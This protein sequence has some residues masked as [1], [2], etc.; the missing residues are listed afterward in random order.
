MQ[1]KFEGIDNFRDYG[2][3]PS[4]FGGRVREGR[5]YRSAHHG[6]ATDEDLNQLSA[7][8]LALL[9]DLRRP[10]ERQREPSRRH[11]GFSAQVLEDDHPDPAADGY[12][13]FLAQSDHSVASMRA[14][15][16]DYY[17]KAPFEPRIVLIFRRHLA[18]LSAS[19]GPS[20]I[21][22]AAGK[23]R[24]GVLAALVHHIL[25]VDFDH[26]LK[27]YLLTNDPDRIERRLQTFGDHVETLV[28]RRPSDEAIR[29]TL[30]VEAV[31][32][33][34]AFTR[35]RDECGDT[36]A[37]LE[38]VLGIGGAMRRSLQERLIDA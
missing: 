2:G 13:A 24:T 33:E 19:D 38:K 34:R 12:Q 9:T 20:L 3:Y 23:D 16:L 22:C 31:Y 8:N 30:G 26:T 29:A 6:R 4:Q 14:F 5:L 1:P 27:D 18:A 15:L 35:I 32:L 17:A 21:H 25:G 37:Y 7:L 36:D 10:E 11:A 28:G